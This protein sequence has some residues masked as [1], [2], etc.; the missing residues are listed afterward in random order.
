MDKLGFVKGF[1]IYSVRGGNSQ[2][3]ARAGTEDMAEIVV[4]SSGH[5]YRLDL[6]KLPDR[7]Q[8]VDLGGHIGT[9]S[10]LVDKLTKGKATVYS[11]EPDEDNF[12]ILSCNLLINNVKSV[13]AYNSAISN[14]NGKGYLKREK[15]NTDAYYLDSKTNGSSNC[16]VMTLKKALSKYEPITID[17]LKLDIEGGEYDL[18]DHAETLEFILKKV[19]YICME[20][21]DISSKK[22]YSRLRKVIEP[23]FTVVY[24][25]GNVLI[26]KNPNW[27]NGGH[28]K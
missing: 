26:L 22:N 18:F 20:Y 9:F 15:L 5:E 6:I 24:K 25:R 16:E 28:K 13:K 11:Y 4:V 17:L 23:N 7:P 8:V 2:F 21:H 10:I 19:H 27:K 1:V 3:V 12:R 14:Y